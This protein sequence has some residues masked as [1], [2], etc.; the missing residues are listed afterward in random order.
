MI[1]Q[2]LT[3]CIMAVVVL[4]NAAQLNATTLSFNPNQTMPVAIPDNNATGITRTYTVTGIPAG[5]TVN[6]VTMTLTFSVTH[7][8]VGDLRTTL[9]SPDAE[10]HRL[11]YDIG[12][13]AS[14]GGAGDSS[15]LTGPYTLADTGATTLW[16]GAGGG[17]DTFVVPSGTYRTTNINVNTATSINTTFGYPGVP[18]AD[19]LFGVKKEKPLRPESA[20]LTNGTWTLVMSDNATGDTGTLSVARLDIDYIVPTAANATVNGRL[21]TPEGRGLSNAEV[22]IF[23]LSTGAIESTRSSS[24][25]HFE[26]SDLPVGNDYVISVF[27]RRFQFSDRVISLNED[28]TDLVLQANSF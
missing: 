11:F 6:F 27:S 4:G 14:P 10:V 20:E 7:T 16:T 18:F 17:G 8:W 12:D 28:V 22:R 15:N 26:F 5:A 1:R 9:T 3:L 25:G 24:F 19:S 23:N 21:L 2:I 13:T